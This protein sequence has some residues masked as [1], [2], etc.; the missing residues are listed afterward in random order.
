[1]EEGEEEFGEV[2]E[3]EEKCSSE[4]IYRKHLMGIP[5]QCE[6][7][8]IRN[9]EVWNLIPRDEGILILTGR[10]NMDAFW[11]TESSKVGKN[12]G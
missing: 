9:I 7:C 4:V 10:E 5:F 12:L 8:H 1:M 6:L 11:G 2:V 3:G